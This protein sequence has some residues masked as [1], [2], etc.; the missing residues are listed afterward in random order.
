M[1]APGSRKGNKIIVEGAIARIVIVSRRRGK[2][3]TIIDST[4]VEV[5]SAYTWSLSS[6]SRKD[7][8]VLRAFTNARLPDGKKRPLM[9]YHLLIG[10]PPAGQM[11]DHIDG[12]PLNNCRTN[13]RVVT[14]R[15]NLCNQVRCRGVSFHKAAAKWQAKIQCFGV[16][17]FLGLFIN[18][19]DAEAAYQKA[20]A[21]RDARLF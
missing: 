12:N 6:Q 4:D 10:K 16:Q 5:A 14:S 8:T 3:E 7:A 17:H 21:E 20:K 11:V 2:T 1:A 19:A 15:Q 9:L 13:L 18:R